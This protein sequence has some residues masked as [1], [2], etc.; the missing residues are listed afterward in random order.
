MKLKVVVYK[1]SLNS[2]NIF[3]LRKNP[4]ELITLVFNNI[5][6]KNST[7]FKDINNTYAIQINNHAF[8]MDNIV[9]GRIIM[10]K[11][12]N[13]IEFW[14]NNTQQI[15]SRVEENNIIEK[16][17][18]F[19]ERNTQ[20]LIFEERGK[21]KK[22]KTIQVFSYIVNYNNNDVHIDLN[23][24]LDKKEAKIRIGNLRK[25]TLAHFEIIPNNPHQKLWSIFE[26]MGE[27]LESTNS[28]HQFRNNDG[29]KY[30][31]EV[32]DLVD[33]VNEG[34]SRM[35]I[36]GGY[37]MEDQYEEVRSHDLTRRIYR[38]VEPSDEGRKQG[39]WEILKEVLNM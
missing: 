12:N 7:T 35:Y 5:N 16:V 38:N 4:E 1:I 3:N 19:Y 27:S 23:P 28:V 26:Q 6:K 8:G 18:F 29:L 14:N 37:N 34:R 33:E 9:F 10:Y 30:T 36:I 13:I 22:E 24:V 25:I 15:E 17:H 32:D 21:I 2:G 11:E 31:E 39:L 20:Y